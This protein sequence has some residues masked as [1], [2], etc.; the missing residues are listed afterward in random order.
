MRGKAVGED[1]KTLEKERVN[2]VVEIILWLSM[3]VII[4]NLLALMKIRLC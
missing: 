1:G 2:I 3:Y 4:T